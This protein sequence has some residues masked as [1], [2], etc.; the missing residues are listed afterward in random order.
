MEK[1]EKERGNEIKRDGEVEAQE[2]RWR[3][4]ATLR[5]TKLPLTAFFGE[6][7]IWSGRH[8]PLRQFARP[9]KL[10]N[11]HSLTRSLSLFAQKSYL[12]RPSFFSSSVPQAIHQVSLSPF[13]VFVH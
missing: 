9:G 3:Q 4:S 13:T 12:F 1:R 2:G 10:A 6:I 11:A 8:M 5:E 7:G